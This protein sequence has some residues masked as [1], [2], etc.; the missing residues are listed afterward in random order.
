MDELVQDLVSALDDS[1]MKKE[2]IDEHGDMSATSETIDREL[3]RKRRTRK[4]RTASTSSHL[5]SSIFNNLVVVN[6]IHSSC[7]SSLDE[8]VKDYVESFTANC[9]DES[10]SHAN[11]WNNRLKNVVL[12]T[13]L[14]DRVHHKRV[15]KQATPC[16]CESDSHTENGITIPV[17]RKHRK[18]KLKRMTIDGSPPGL[19]RDSQGPASGSCDENHKRKQ[20]NKS[21]PYPSAEETDKMCC[22]TTKLKKE[23]KGTITCLICYQKSC[24]KLILSNNMYERNGLLTLVPNDNI[25]MKTDKAN[26]I[27]E[28]IQ[29]CQCNCHLNQ[30]KDESS[31]SSTSSNSD[32][33][34]A[35]FTQ[36]D[37]GGDG[38][39][40]M[41]DFYAES[42]N[43][44]VWGIPNICGMRCLP[45]SR[46]LRNSKDETLWTHK[47][48]ESNLPGNPYV[49]D[50]KIK[51]FVTGPLH[52]TDHS[53][54]GFHARNNRL[55]GLAA[56]SIRRGRRRAKVKKVKEKKEL[57][58]HSSLSLSKLSL[59][60]RSKR[61][62]LDEIKE[63]VCNNQDWSSNKFIPSFKATQSTSVNDI[64]NNMNANPLENCDIVSTSSMFNGNVTK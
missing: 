45:W 49:Y 6:Q 1:S 14:Q 37:A 35:N 8:A 38:D 41:T 36:D 20:P 31:I 3:Y 60:E 18:K 9:S 28:E 53:R 40:E 13:G 54:R 52:I 58:F 55:P 4:R 64:D 25:S 46:G 47:I 23:R 39:D 2:E 21:T 51:R 17:L 63:T 30:G 15:F 34:S 33:D 22:K 62:K 5:V 56:R 57:D 24:D 42:D 50:E 29:S 48:E 7:S 26:S 27:E 12:S 11:T 61:I 10:D 43:G 44:P 19:L 16:N 59:S 32:T